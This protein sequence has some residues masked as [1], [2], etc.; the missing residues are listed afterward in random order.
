MLG[1]A[2]AGFEAVQAM[3]LNAAV[4]GSI[5]VVPEA[6]LVMMMALPFGYAG[7]RPPPSFTPLPGSLRP[8][9]ILLRN[10][11]KFHWPV[12]SENWRRSLP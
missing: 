8:S 9:T 7:H 5:L 1:C 4:S 6:C 11:G 2:D 12:S 10:A 3:A